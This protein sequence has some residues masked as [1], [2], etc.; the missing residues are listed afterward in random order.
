MR[1]LTSAFTV[2]SLNLQQLWLFSGM[3]FPFQWDQVEAFVRLPDGSL[4]GWCERFHCYKHI[5][6]GI[7]SH[8]FLV[9]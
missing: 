9:N 8:L 7:V 5:I 2:T 6:Y 4:F 1:F 3:D